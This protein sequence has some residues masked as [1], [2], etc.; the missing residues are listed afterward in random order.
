MPANI[1]VTDHLNRFED[2]LEGNGDVEECQLALRALV[3]WQRDPDL[4]EA[5]R[6]RARALVE[7]FAPHASYGLGGTGPLIPEQEP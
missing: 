1:D 3:R 4:T 2:L 6:E 5:S 7:R